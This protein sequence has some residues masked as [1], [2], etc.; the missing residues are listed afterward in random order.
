MCRHLFLFFAVTILTTYSLLSPTAHITHY[1]VCMGLPSFFFLSTSMCHRLNQSCLDADNLA[2]F[3]H[4]HANQ[5]HVQLM[6]HRT[7]ISLSCKRLKQN[8]CLLVL[9]YVCVCV[10]SSPIP[11]QLSLA[12]RR[13]RLP[14]PVLSSCFLLF[15][16]SSRLH[17]LR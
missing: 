10:G 4:I 14:T 9:G 7:M 3:E 1:T 2:V 11:H 6:V 16:H 8:R 5:R 15:H 12:S 13:A 17:L